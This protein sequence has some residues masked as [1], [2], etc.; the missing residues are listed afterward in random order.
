MAATPV[1]TLVNAFLLKAVKSQATHV[2]IIQ[3]PNGG[4]VQLWFEGAWHEELAV[5]EVLRTPLVRRLGVMIGVLPPPRGKPWFGSL[6]MELGGDRHY[7]AVAID[8]D[9][10][11]LHALVE[12]VDETSFK[13]RRQPRPPS[14]HPY[15]AG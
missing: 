9:H 5:P 3:V 8:R 11:T 6:C 14:P 15:R 13:A 12:L 10:D 7:F 1:E 4:S 2:R